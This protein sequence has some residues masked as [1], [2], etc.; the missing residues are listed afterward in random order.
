[1]RWEEEIQYVYIARAYMNA[2]KPDFKA[3][4]QTLTL[5]MK[6]MLK[7]L[8]YCY[9]GDAYYGDKITAYSAYMCFFSADNTLLRAKMQL[10]V[11]LKELRHM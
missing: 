5:L 1:M 7:S 8:K 2:D 3:A 6:E 11:L 4:I 10:G 9:F